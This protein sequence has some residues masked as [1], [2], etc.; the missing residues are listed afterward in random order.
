MQHALVRRLQQAVA[1]YLEPD[2]VIGRASD[3]TTPHDHGCGE[4]GC[5]SYGG[6]Y[7]CTRA[8][9]TAVVEGEQGG[10]DEEEGEEAAR[11]QLGAVAASVATVTPTL[12][13]TATATI[14]QQP[15]LHYY[16]AWLCG[17]QDETCAEY[18]QAL[19]E[20]TAIGVGDGDNDS[21]NNSSGVVRQRQTELPQNWQLLVKHIYMRWAL[22]STHLSTAKV[23]FIRVM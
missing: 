2:I 9:A 23:F 10:R 12:T 14:P 7:S 21:D 22:P 5:S 20:A 16:Y 19:L 17:L 13:A 15:W 3:T 18:E 6:G 11:Q 4:M 1:T 8:A